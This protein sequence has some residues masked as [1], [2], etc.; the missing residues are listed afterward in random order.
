MSRVI[1]TTNFKYRGLPAEGPGDEFLRLDAALQRRLKG[2]PE[3]ERA[4]QEL[5]SLAETLTLCAAD[6]ARSLKVAAVGS[7]LFDG[8]KATAILNYASGDTE[9]YGGFSLSPKEWSEELGLVPDV[10]ARE[11]VESQRI[12]LE[13]ASAHGGKVPIDAISEALHA[14]NVDHLKV[15]SNFAR[16]VLEIMERCRSGLGD[17]HRENS[18]ASDE[19]QPL[20]QNVSN[21]RKPLEQLE[22]LI[23]GLESFEI[24]NRAPAFGQV[25][26]QGEKFASLE[27]ALWDLAEGLSTYCGRQRAKTEEEL[28]GTEREVLR[29]ADYRAQLEEA[30]DDREL[31]R[32]EKIADELNTQG[33]REK[34]LA[35]GLVR[36]ASLTVGAKDGDFSEACR[37]LAITRLAGLADRDLFAQLHW[38]TEFEL[39]PASGSTDLLSRVKAD[40]EELKPKHVAVE[41]ER[42][43]VDVAELVKFGI[44]GDVAAALSNTGASEAIA[45]FVGDKFK[46]L[47]IFAP[48]QAKVVRFGEALLREG[49]GAKVER[50]LEACARRLTSHRGEETFK[51]ACSL[52]DWESRLAKP[53]PRIG[54]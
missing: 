38:L 37:I 5:T 2:V 10:L 1:E 49:D 11:L 47:R 29:L 43:R 13:L 24:E 25:R 35:Y 23:A 42:P 6:F 54:R 8:M 27:K 26:Q 20:Q 52:P 33:A 36:G 9:S 16:S 51:Q 7:S 45:L 41:K 18:A 22:K 14:R 31:D 44:A 46:A 48:Y 50:Y 17:Q 21:I 15:V 34:A 12:S 40:M 30:L 53:A 3:L 39:L 28:T 19:V 4:A 32:V